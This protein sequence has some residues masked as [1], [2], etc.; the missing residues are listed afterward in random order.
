MSVFRIGLF[1]EGEQLNW[2]EC[3]KMFWQEDCGLFHVVNIV[4]TLLGCV[5]IA[6]PPFLFGEMDPHLHGSNVYENAF[7]GAMAALFGTLFAANV[8][9]VIRTLRVSFCSHCLSSKVGFRVANERCSF[10][11]GNSLFGYHD[12]VRSLCYCANF[13]DDVGVEWAVPTGV[14]TW[15]LPDGTFGDFQFCRSNLVDH[16]SA[17]GTGRTG[18][19]CSFCWHRFRFRVAGDYRLLV[20]FF[21]ATLGLNNHR[22][23]FISLSFAVDDRLTRTGDIL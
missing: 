3:G 16:G 10:V 13:P 23:T 17:E 1:N 18:G 15:S 5:L 2:N 20:W 21:P 22:N 7:W 11:S 14:W 8:Y 12:V 19:Y 6:R 9:V 4:L